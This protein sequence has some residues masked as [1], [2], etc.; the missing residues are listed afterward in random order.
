VSLGC[1]GRYSTH[2]ADYAAVLSDCTVALWFGGVTPGL[3]TQ[4]RY[5]LKLVVAASLLATPVGRTDDEDPRLAQSPSTEAPK[6]ENAAT[7]SLPPLRPAVTTLCCSGV[8]ARNRLLVACGAPLPAA[9]ASC[10]GWRGRDVGTVA[11]WADQHNSVSMAGHVD[12]GVARRCPRAQLFASAAYHVAGAMGRPRRSSQRKLGCD[13]R[14]DFG[15]AGVV[16]S[17][18]VGTGRA[19]SVAEVADDRCRTAFTLGLPTCNGERFVAQSLVAFGAQT[20]IAT[21]LSVRTEPR[22]DSPVVSVLRAW[23]KL[24]ITATT[25]RIPVSVLPSRAPG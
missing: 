15:R 25:Q 1:R 5:L 4:A 20:L 9:A 21:L 12:G 16:V 19:P 3:V 24:R 7:K 10:C 23:T 14:T 2:M 6:G 18:S 17:A 22:D 8:S 11:R 13:N